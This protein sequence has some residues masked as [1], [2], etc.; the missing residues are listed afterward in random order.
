MKIGQIFEIADEILKQN[1]IATVEETDDIL[2]Y[3]DGVYRNGE[4]K[5][6]EIIIKMIEDK[7][8]DFSKKILNSILEIIKVRTIITLRHF[9]HNP[10][11][12]CLKNGIFDLDSNVFTNYSSF[13]DNPYKST[14]QLN[15]KY[16]PQAECKEIDKFLTQLFGKEKKKIYIYIFHVINSHKRYGKA[17]VLKSN[18]QSGKSTFLNFIAKIIGEENI[19][20]VKLNRL[21]NKFTTALFRNSLFNLDHDI[22]KKEIEKGNRNLKRVISDNLFQAELMYQ[23]SFI[24]PNRTEFAFSTNGDLNIYKPALK[25]RLDIVKMKSIIVNKKEDLDRFENALLVDTEILQKITTDEEL[26]GLFNKLIEDIS[27][28]C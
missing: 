24:F 16:N 13:N 1:H 12:I 20:N 19:S 6:S 2:L 7:N 8:Y 21:D 26:S 4:N 27:I 15:I 10:N 5:V 14:I 25:R 17:L 28:N 11:F 9:N 3:R 22:I 23:K 18:T